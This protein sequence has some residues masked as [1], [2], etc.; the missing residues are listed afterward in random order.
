[1]ANLFF[2]DFL[3][4]ADISNFLDMGP[5]A[6][7][8]EAEAASNATELFTAAALKKRKPVP[9]IKRSGK[10]LNCAERIS[11]KRRWCDSQC[12]DEWE[13]NQ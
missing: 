7:I 4:S 10:C 8:D 2:S 9:P 5:C 12:R 13:A 1:V 3:F 6:M 11:K